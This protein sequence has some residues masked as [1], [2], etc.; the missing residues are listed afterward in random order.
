M[1]AVFGPGTT[2]GE[3]ADFIR[4]N[5]TP[6]RVA[7]PTSQDRRPA[8]PP[9]AAPVLADA[10]RTGDRRALARLLTAVENH[11]AVAEHALRRLYPL[12]GG[13][14]L[15]GITGPPGA[16]KSTLVA[17][18]IAELRKAGPDRGRRGRRPVLPDHGRRPPGRPGPDAVLRRGRRRVHPLDG[19]ARARGRPRGHVH[20][21]RRG[22]RCGR[23]RRRA[24]RDR[25]HG[26]ERGRGGRRGRHDRRPRGAGDGR[27]GPGDQ[28]RPARGR[29]HRRRQQGRPARRPADGRAAAGDADVPAAARAGTA[30]GRSVPA[31]P[32]APGGAG[33]HRVHRRG[34][35]GAAGR[36]G[37]APGHAGGRRHAGG[38]P[39]AGGG[40]GPR[41]PGGAPLGAAP[42]PGRRRRPPT[43]RSMPSPATS[44][45]PY[46]AADRLLAALRTEEP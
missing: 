36:A 1:A 21:R 16:G 12:A 11:T 39:G 6:A 29:G 40:A 8:A 20:V 34:R 3:V 35:A 31:A 25:R 13:A 19:L 37:P 33:H 4:A 41:R 30:R 43:R 10:A 27:R 2:I 44:S 14:H 9:N 28:G 32:Q 7:W 45:I 42:R 24:A 26:P 5:A 38:A 15:V 18:L 23:L 46:A 22:A 17:A